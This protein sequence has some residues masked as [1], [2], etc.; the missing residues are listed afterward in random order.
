MDQGR[1]TCLE[2]HCTTIPALLSNLLTP[3]ELSNLNLTGI[4]WCG[5]RIGG[6]VLPNK[7]KIK[8]CETFTRWLLEM[9]GHKQVGVR[10]KA[11]ANVLTFPLHVSAKICNEFN[12]NREGLS[13]PTTSKYPTTQPA[14]IEWQN[15]IRR[16]QNFRAKSQKQPLR[17]L[18]KSHQLH[19]LHA[20]S[21]PLLLIPWNHL[22]FRQTNGA[23]FCKKVMN[24]PLNR[25]NY[26]QHTH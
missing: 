16:S 18:Y 12:Y 13:F 15:T 17:W 25:S 23:A 3:A 2:I 11:W 4:C 6:N 24:P 22:F 1:N 20:I 10:M 26:P 5:I 9:S 8:C 7:C 19:Q 21:G 14:F